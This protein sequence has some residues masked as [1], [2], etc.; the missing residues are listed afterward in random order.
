MYN[1]DTTTTTTT[2]TT[3][4]N[5]NTTNTDTNTNT[6]DNNNDNSSLLR[7]VVPAE[8]YTGSSSRPV[9]V[10]RYTSTSSYASTCIS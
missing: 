1:D 7:R 10:R 4:T 2:T 3:N 5:T 9:Q 6:N 8:A